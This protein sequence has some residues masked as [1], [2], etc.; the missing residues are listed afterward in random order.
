MQLLLDGI[1]D[2]HAHGGVLGHCTDLAEQ[3]RRVDLAVH[4]VKAGHGVLP[5]NGREVVDPSHFHLAHILS[6]WGFLG[7]RR[8]L[9][10]CLGLRSR[11][12]CVRAGADHPGQ[13]GLGFGKFGL[14]LG[15]E[16]IARVG[17]RRLL[18]GRHGCLG[19]G[20]GLD[21]GL[22]PV[23]QRRR[24]PAAGRLG[25]GRGHRGDRRSGRWRAAGCHLQ[26][27]HVQRAGRSLA[28]ARNHVLAVQHEGGIEACLGGQAARQRRAWHPARNRRE[29]ALILSDQP[30]DRGQHVAGVFRT[31][32]LAGRPDAFMLH[33]APP[34]PGAAAGYCLPMACKTRSRLLPC[35]LV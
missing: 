16:L 20:G 25:H 18:R 3:V 6:H 34:G 27:R 32:R 23:G 31:R 21:C 4:L 30:P 11:C 33:D 22:G 14:F 15:R 24:T 35:R 17:K 26:L 10:R 2:Q 28:T 9:E 1:A 5:R 8:V 29:P 19:Q 12:G 13:R 7:G